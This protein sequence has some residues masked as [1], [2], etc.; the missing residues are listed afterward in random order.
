[1]SFDEDL[2]S[3]VTETITISFGFLEN[4]LWF[5]K[6]VLLRFLMLSTEKNSS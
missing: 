4:F 6:P 3:A 2:D 5:L 1:M